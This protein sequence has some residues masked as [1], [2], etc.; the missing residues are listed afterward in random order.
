MVSVSGTARS[1]HEALEAY[2]QHLFRLSH[3]P[4]AASRL[5]LSS[6]AL[7]SATPSVHS[8]RGA[9]VAT[10][11]VGNIPISAEETACRPRSTPAPASAN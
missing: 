4:G 10:A 5:G 9:A 3:R 11:C 8:Q 1:L 2:S 7:D 6:C